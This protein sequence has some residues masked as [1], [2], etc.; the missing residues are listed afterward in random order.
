MLFLMFVSFTYYFDA[1]IPQ[2]AAS[3]NFDISDDITS[4]QP[5]SIGAKGDGMSWVEK[6]EGA[7]FSSCCDFPQFDSLVPTMTSQYLPITT[8]GD[9]FNLV[10]MTTKG[11]NFSACCH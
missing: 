7:N 3:P 2:L 11:A 6:T 4:S 5:T 9:I 10:G 8:D 1:V